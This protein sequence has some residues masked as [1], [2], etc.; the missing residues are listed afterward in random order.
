MHIADAVGM[1]I[2]AL[3]SSKNHVRIWQPL[4][5]RCT[6]L[7]RQVDCG[8]CFRATCPRENLCMDLIEP[9]EVVA[10]LLALRG[11]DG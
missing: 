9:R 1:P 10:A 5:P 7:N 2:V 6:I 11:G 3:F 8:P 4:E